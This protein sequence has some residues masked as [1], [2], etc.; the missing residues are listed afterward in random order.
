MRVSV[1]GE[2]RGFLFIRVKLN[3][4]I[5]YPSTLSIWDPSRAG[6]TKENRIGQE[7]RFKTLVGNKK[8]QLR[9][10][11]KRRVG[12]KRENFRKVILHTH[13]RRVR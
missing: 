7:K 4:L 3:I 6:N 9:G 12:E 10:I 1:Q 2:I 13:L 5:F 8:K 11:E